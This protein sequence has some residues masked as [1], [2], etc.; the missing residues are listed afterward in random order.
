V[1]P[2]TQIDVLNHEKA[3]LVVLGIAAAVAAR[4]L[5]LV[6]AT[7]AA[8]LFAFTAYPAATYLVAVVVALGTLVL[9]RW[10]PRHG[11][12][13][14]L[15]VLTMV[16][17]VV[18]V[19]NVDRLIGL[20]NSYFQLV[21]KTDNGDT[22]EALYHAALA[23]LHSPVFSSFFTGDITVVGNLSGT[24][25]VVPVHNDFLS[26]TL[27]GGFVA[28][29]LLLGLFL[30]ANGLV[31]RTLPV[32]TDP[33]QRRT[34][35]VLLASLN[36]AAVSAF[37]NPIFMNPGASAVTFALLAGLLAACR[38]PPA[39]PAEPADDALAAEAALAR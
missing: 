14:V 30:F 2:G 24:D 26:I 33:W 36:A 4:D 34:V 3:F 27:G 37:A 39:E 21:G 12:R 17:T 18:A 10:A 22:R 25:R 8:A 11:T 31:L 5:L 13:V 15:A 9:V 32:L 29:A 23:R 28:A 20:T 6:G 1:L 7:V 38:V 35:V 16:G 19:L